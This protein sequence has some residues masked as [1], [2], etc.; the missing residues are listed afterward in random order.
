M[1]STGTSASQLRLRLL[2]LLKRYLRRCIE[3]ISE[4]W[5]GLEERRGNDLHVAVS[6]TPQEV[7]D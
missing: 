6:Q 5:E 4:E 2:F 3:K 1:K 7:K